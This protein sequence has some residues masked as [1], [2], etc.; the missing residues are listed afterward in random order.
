MFK[1]RTKSLR[2]E[3]QTLKFKVLRLGLCD[4]RQS[5]YGTMSIHGN[6][7]RLAAGLCFYGLYLCLYNT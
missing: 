4:M 7:N 6:V 2:R 3:A 1:V 5:K